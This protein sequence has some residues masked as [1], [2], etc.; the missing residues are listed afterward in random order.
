MKV[1][2]MVL[3][4]DQKTNLKRMHDVY[5]LT[6]AQHPENTSYSFLDGCAEYF[7]EYVIALGDQIIAHRLSQQVIIVFRD[8]KKAL[9]SILYKKWQ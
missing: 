7:C 2:N 9:A 5:H 1:N 6:V 4:E 8:C 3:S